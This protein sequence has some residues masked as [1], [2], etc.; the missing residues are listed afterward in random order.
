MP[1]VRA[2]W[3]K[4]KY[5]LDRHEFYSAYHFAMQ[6]NR[7]KERLFVLDN[8]SAAK[9]TDYNSVNVQH[10]VDN[11]A[12]EDIAVERAELENNIK[13]VV[14]S[15]KESDPELWMWILK[16]ATTEGVSYYSLSNPCDGSRAMHCGKDMYYDR[17]R[18]F[19][20][21]LWHKLV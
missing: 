7:W 19:Y 4:G 14:D 21:V 6:F 18:K 5:K 10:S 17:R 15:A 11:N 1:K 20:W 13:K 2:G 16:A 8:K 3:K 12:V 9:A